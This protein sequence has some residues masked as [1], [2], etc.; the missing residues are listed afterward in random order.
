MQP[1]VIETKC[2][3]CL[4]EV[5]AAFQYAAL[6]T[7]WKINVWQHPGFYPEHSTFDLPPGNWTLLGQ[8]DAIS[9]EVAV[10]IVGTFTAWGITVFNSWNDIDIDFDT[11]T[12]SLRS[13]ITHHGF[14][15]DNCVVLI[16]KL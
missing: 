11:A 5:Q 15:P 4:V 10:G 16:E 6:E 9:E 2:R 13:L 7:P 12:E 3:I 1:K 8:F 14:T